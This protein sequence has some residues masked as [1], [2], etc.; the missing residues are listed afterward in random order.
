MKWVKKKSTNDKTITFETIENM[1]ITKARELPLEEK[2][3][4]L[5]NKC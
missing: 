1:S 3:V 5:E 2:K 4:W